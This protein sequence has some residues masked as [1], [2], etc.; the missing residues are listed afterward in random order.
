[1]VKEITDDADKTNDDY[2]EAKNND[3]NN[4]G[5][6]APGQHIYT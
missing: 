1:M 5:S 4:S 6:P 3:D 2:D